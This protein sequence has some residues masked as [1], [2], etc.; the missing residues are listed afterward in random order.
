MRLTLP[1]SV[2]CFWTLGEM[3]AFEPTMKMLGLSWDSI[4]LRVAAGTA[5][6]RVSRIESPLRAAHAAAGIAQSGR[7]PETT[8]RSLEG[9]PL[10]AEAKRSIA[11]AR[12]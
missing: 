3:T 2:S 5:S 1:S 12:S 8:I 10:A 7:S 9:R 11:A 4:A 6:R